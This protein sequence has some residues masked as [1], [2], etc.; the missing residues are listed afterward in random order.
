M[1]TSICIGAPA[2]CGVFDFGVPSG[3]AAAVLIPTVPR[4]LKLNSISPSA[5]NLRLHP[6]S[7][8]APEISGSEARHGLSWVSEPLDTGSCGNATDV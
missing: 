4:F 8:E 3:P 5:L 7:S 1:Y 2:G 6:T